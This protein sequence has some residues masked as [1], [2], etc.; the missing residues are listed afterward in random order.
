M[1][2]SHNSNL[3]RR[4]EILYEFN[5]P[6]SMVRFKNRYFIFDVTWKDGRLDESLSTFD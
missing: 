3:E 4:F 2:G 1:Y 5:I 6:V